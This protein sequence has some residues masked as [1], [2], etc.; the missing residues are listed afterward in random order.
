MNSWQPGF[1]Q[2]EMTTDQSDFRKGIHLPNA[3]KLF[4]RDSFSD[5]QRSSSR[6]AFKIITNAQYN[7]FFRVTFLFYFLLV[8]PFVLMLLRVD[9]KRKQLDGF[10]LL[11]VA[12]DKS[13]KLETE[14]A[15][16][17]ME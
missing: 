1:K 15:T 16:E 4:I 10:G 3:K 12:N 7:L 13:E 9:C 11:V 17:E 14:L 6:W 5:T 2:S 8:H